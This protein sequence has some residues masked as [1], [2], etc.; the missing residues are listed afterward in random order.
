[1]SESC[2][3]PDIDQLVADEWQTLRDIR[4]AALKESPDAFMARYDV[5]SQF[6]ASTWRAE[7][8]RGA[9]IIG[10][11]NRLP[12]SVIGCTRE[13]HTPPRIR[14]LESLWVA[15]ECRRRGLA[16]C[17]VMHAITRLRE[18]NVRLARLWVLEGN[19]PAIR[20]YR[21][22]GFVSTNFRQPLPDRAGVNEELMELELT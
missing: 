17:M 6:D 22:A 5:E 18:M 9:W 14:Y 4:L 12:V 3:V 2:F 8:D 16:F 11:E 20:L 10:R 21:R 19:D 1:M 13:T 7:F 15:P